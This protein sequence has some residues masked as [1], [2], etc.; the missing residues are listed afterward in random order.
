[1]S[2]YHREN[3]DQKITHDWFDTKYVAK[4][5]EKPVPHRSIAV[6]PDSISV[7]NI[8]GKNESHDDHASKDAALA[9]CSGLE[10]EGFGGER[11]VFP[12]STRVEPISAEPTP[13]ISICRQCGG[14]NRESVGKWS[15][16]AQCDICK[17]FWPPDEIN[18]CLNNS[19]APPESSANL[20]PL[21]GIVTLMPLFYGLW[22]AVLWICGADIELN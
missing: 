21:V 8:A 15:A 4:A 13:T 6:W 14:F 18:I 2:R 11:K 3:P 7:G 19:P 10:R 16:T 22:L 1:M 20:T 17:L 5:P 12:I 9:V